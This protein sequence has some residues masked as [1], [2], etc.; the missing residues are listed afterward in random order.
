MEENA[1][2]E[3]F[4]ASARASEYV[5]PPVENP[6]PAPCHPCSSSRVCPALEE[7]VEEPRDAICDDLDTLLR[8]A[9]VE[10]VRTSRKSPPSLWYVLHPDLAQRGGKGLMESIACIQGQAEGSRG[11]QDQGPMSERFPQDVLQS[12]GVQENQEESQPLHLA[13]SWK[14]VIP[15]FSRKLRNFLLVDLGS[16]DWSSRERSLSGH[17]VESLI[18][19]FAIHLRVALTDEEGDALFGVLGVD[20]MERF[21]GGE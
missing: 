14:Q 17:L 18:S 5:A 4:Y 3:L 12:F 8:E 20:K 16:L 21:Q 6:I 1:R 2:T 19:G 10:R 9:E 13:P 11:P 15:L 7:I